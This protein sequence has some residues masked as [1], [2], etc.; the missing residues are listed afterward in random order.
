MSLPAIVIT[1]YHRTEPLK[2]LLAS[3]AKALYP[4]QPVTLIISVDKSDTGEPAALARDF[5]WPYGDKEVIVHPSHLGLL[6]HQ[7]YVL[8]LA[9][10]YNDLIILE[11]DLMVSPY[12]Y[13]FAQQ[14][15]AFYENAPAIAGVS[16]Y[17]YNM[18]ESSLLRFE[19]IVDG[20][21]VYF[22]Q[23]PSS[24][25]FAINKKHAF[26]FLE[27]YTKGSLKSHN[28]EPLFIKNWP[29]QS[30][31]RYMV[32]YLNEKD[33]YFV[34]PRLSLTT[35]FSPA[36]THSPC[37][38]ELF[39]VPLQT[40][41][42][43]YRFIPFIESKAVYDSYFEMTPACLNKHTALFA[44][45]NYELDLQGGKELPASDAPYVLTIRRTSQHLFSFS[46][47]MKPLLL[48]I[49]FNET[50]KDIFFTLKNHVTEKPRNIHY[51]HA[52]YMHRFTYKML[53]GRFSF[54]KY[55]YFYVIYDLKLFFGKFLK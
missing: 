30:W 7:L 2:R 44:A 49:I 42:V 34:F 11:D 32:S 26:S 31:K 41:N 12:F 4:S 5:Q 43:S 8:G 20:S 23:Y 6:N 33:N 54:L 50:G 16:L 53:A 52:E 14:A 37:A 48:N 17:H 24:W 39:Q 13:G 40:G 19:P 10:K 51:G 28:R 35:N 1:A 55:V 25:G 3:L 45:Y 46:S 47:A 36:G 29:P 21:S 9:E 27:S 22:M 18:S 15:L 38:M